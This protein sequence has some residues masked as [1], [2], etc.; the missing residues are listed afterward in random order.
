MNAAS[1]KSS[2]RG[3]NTRSSR[4]EKTRRAADVSADNYLRPPAGRAASLCI[5]GLTPLSLSDWPGQLAAVVFCQGCPWRC[6]YCHNPHLIP[7]V[8]YTHLTLPTN[9]EV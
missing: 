9:R 5:G 3:L 7:P 8:S 1:L 2:A 4:R 6:G